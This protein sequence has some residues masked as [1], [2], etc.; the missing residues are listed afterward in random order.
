MID[1]A[2]RRLEEHMDVVRFIQNK[3]K[4]ETVFALMLNKIERF[5]I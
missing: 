3:I 5:L 1:E 2:E 4:F